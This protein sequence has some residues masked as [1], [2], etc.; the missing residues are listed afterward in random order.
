MFLMLHSV[1]FPYEMLREHLQVYIPPKCR[2]DVPDNGLPTLEDWRG[3]FHSMLFSG[4]ELGREPL[5]T[6]MPAGESGHQKKNL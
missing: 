4:I 5:D 6:T 1:M 2:F 3:T